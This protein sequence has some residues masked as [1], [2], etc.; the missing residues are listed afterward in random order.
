MCIDNNLSYIYLS[1]YV[2]FGISRA[3]NGIF[4]R[5]FPCFNRVNYVAHSS[6]DLLAM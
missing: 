4:T 5:K 2:V 3:T 6:R 1:I